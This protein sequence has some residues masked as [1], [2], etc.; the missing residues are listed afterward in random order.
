MHSKKYKLIRTF[1]QIIQGAGHHVYADRASIFNAMVNKIAASVDTGHLPSMEAF[2]VDMEIEERKQ[3][4][5]NDFN[6]FLN[7]GK[8]DAKDG[9]FEEMEESIS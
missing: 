2:R 1:L 3:G 5:G 8:D 9:E 4:V 6:A 7:V